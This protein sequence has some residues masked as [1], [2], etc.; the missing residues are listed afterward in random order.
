MGK[1]LYPLKCGAAAT[2][3]FFLFA[4][5]VVS[6]PPATVESGTS[7]NVLIENFTG[8]WCSYC[9]LGASELKE[10]QKKFETMIIIS[11]HYNDPM[12]TPEGTGLNGKVNNA[13]FPSAMVDRMLFSGQPKLPLPR[14]IWGA[15]I[16]EAAAVSPRFELS[17][18][19]SYDETARK[20]D[21][22][23]TAVPL[24]DLA[25]TYRLNVMVT[26]DSLNYAQKALNTSSGEMFPY[27]HVNV[28]RRAFTGQT[29][30]AF[31][32]A[33]VKEG[34]PLRKTYSFVLAKNVAAGNAH[35]TVFIHE[36]VSN[37]LGPVQ[38]ALQF[39]VI[40]PHSPISVRETDA[41]VD[42]VL[43]GNYPNP[44]N[45]ST[46]VSFTLPS[47]GQVSLVVYDITGRKIR[48][49]I[50]GPMSAGSHSVV[51]D[52]RDSAGKTVSSGVYLSRLTQGER[53]VSRRM[54]LMK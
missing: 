23:I 40:A 9:P 54:T 36:T 48:D 14:E 50:S 3:L 32:D 45:P 10:L 42:F 41:P 33:P 31:I 28:L 18:T 27:Y 17:A 29:G 22:D 20:L 49:L 37:Y 4:A 8:T 6:A 26:E 1:F 24:R 25:G 13:L 44:F 5:G 46:T 39:P 53:T 21:L 7:R 30:V 35:I 15:K 12:D 16:A 43:T 52:G 19:W 47:S 11:Y 34:T 51:W 38:Q 2:L